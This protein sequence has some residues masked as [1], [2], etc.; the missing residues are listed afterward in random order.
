MASGELSRINTSISALN[1]LNSLN[2]INR[3]MNVPSLRL[4]TG[5]RINSA[6]D[7]AAGFTIAKKMDVRSQGLG[8]AIDDIGPAKNLMTVAEGHLNNISDI[9]AKMKSKSQQA[10][11]DT[12]STDERAAVLTEL[13]EMNTQINSEVEQARWSGTALLGAG[14]TGLDFQIGAGV[15]ATSDELNFNVA[16]QIWSGGSTTFDSSGLDVEA[17]GS[18]V[19]TATETVV[20]TS[21]VT[22]SV[23][24]SATIN[25]NGSELSTGSYTVEVSSVG[26][27]TGAEITIK[28]KDSQGRYVA[29]DDNGTASAG[30][31]EN[32]LVYTLT[33]TNAGVLDLGVGITVD[34][35]AVATASGAT[36][37]ASYSVDYSRAGNSVDSQ[38]HSQAFMTNI[39][40]AIDKVSSALTYIGSSINRLSY[41]Q[42]SLSIAMTNTEAAHARIVDADMA[43]EQLE[44]TKL[45]ILQQTATAMLAQAN[46][47]PQAI[48]GLF[49]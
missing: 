41:Q 37:S 8:V 13:Q 47:A 31:V 6:A 21:G 23:G 43:Y 20:A 25:S 3:Q 1:A 18:L 38:D 5:K 42:E 22:A 28:L 7:D 46:G 16:S 9:L 44:S 14:T 19:R 35:S 40:S 33:G 26:A 36:T 48:L 10:A 12:L 49:R 15:T 29:I 39:D 4:A 27:T 45:Q 32:E 24:T 30:T 11:N 34:L 17:S 2:R